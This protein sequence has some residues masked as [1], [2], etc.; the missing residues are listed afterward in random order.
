[1]KM[2]AE[3]E[4]SSKGDTTSR[5]KLLHQ[6]TETDSNES[7]NRKQLLRQVA[8]SVD[9]EESLEDFYNNKPSTN[10]RPSII[11]QPPL[12]GLTE[13]ETSNPDDNNDAQQY[14]AFKV[15]NKRRKSM[16]ESIIDSLQM[17]NQRR[18]SNTESIR[19]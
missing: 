14:E 19:E 3:T 13:L 12:G 7:L 16:T 6:S 8:L 15:H 4:E 11:L 2:N 5:T 1:G 10:R 18:K 9:I 17:G